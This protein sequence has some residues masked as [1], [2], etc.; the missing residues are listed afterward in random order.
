M[1]CFVLNYY[2][3][4]YSAL[5]ERFKTGVKGFTQIELIVTVLVIGILA[6]I[7][8]PNLS[9][10]LRQKQV[11]DALNQVDFALQET[12][13]EAVKRHQTCE[14]RIVRSTHPTIT[15]DCLV[16]GNRV[17]KSI[18]LNHNR[19]VEPWIISFNERGEN[20]SV[21]NDPGTLRISSNEGV[22]QSKCLVISV[23][24][25]LRRNGKYENGKCITP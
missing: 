1:Y 23:G 19:T 21:S 6:A 25:G 4:T 5:R 16:T 18:V 2:G 22:V 7:A 15:G 8:A 14:L 10:W 3:R 11:D 12:Q 24:I 20:R 9:K 13:S 17:L